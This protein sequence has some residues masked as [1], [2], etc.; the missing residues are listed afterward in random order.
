MEIQDGEAW[1]IFFD[2]YTNF[3]EIAAKSSNIL[4]TNEC[5]FH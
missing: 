3:I 2:S 1:V 4:A 5:T